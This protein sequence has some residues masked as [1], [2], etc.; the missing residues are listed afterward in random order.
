MPIPGGLRH[1]VG[2]T[3]QG[4]KP[5]AGHNHTLNTQNK[6]FREVCISL[7]NPDYSEETSSDTEEA[8]E[9][10]ASHTH[11]GWKQEST[12]GINPRAMTTKPLCICWIC[13]GSLEDSGSSEAESFNTQ[14]G[15]SNS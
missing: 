5:I 15:R 12:P 13:S 2:D 3:G 1:K 6:Q 7:D 4:A 9:Q 11:T 10:H 14:T 8:Q